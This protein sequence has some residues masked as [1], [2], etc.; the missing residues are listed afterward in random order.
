MNHDEIDKKYLYNENKRLR[1]ELREANELTILHK[2]A[3]FQL[4]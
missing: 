1:T 3:V 4:S 2:N